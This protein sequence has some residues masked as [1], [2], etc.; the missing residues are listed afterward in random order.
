M[1]RPQYGVSVT[2][3][4][5]FRRDFFRA[6]DTGP[7]DPATDARYLPLYEPE[8]D[9]ILRLKE[10]INFAHG[11][12]AQLLSGYR[13]AGKSTELRRLRQ[14]LQAEG[15]DYAVL[16]I[17]VE[18]YLDLHMPIDITEFLLA[19]CGAVGEKLQEGEFLKGSPLKASLGQRF[20]NFLNSEVQL[21]EF[22][23]TAKAGVKAEGAEVGLDASAKVELKTNPL[24]RQKIQAALANSL[25]QFTTEVRGF[26]AECALAVD[27]H[28]KGAG[29]V[30]LVDSIEHARGTNETEAKVHE[31]LERL[32]ADH[33]DK[34][35]LPGV[36]L[37]Y[38]VPPWL[39]IRRPNIGAPYSGAG[40]HTLPAQ[41][42]RTYAPGD[43]EGK[44]FAPGLKRLTELVAKRGD[45]Q[46]LLGNKAALEELIL[47]TGGHLRDLIRLLQ[48]VAVETTTLPATTK[49][50][51]AA[52]ERLRAQFTPIPLDDVR[53]LAEIARSHE[54]DLQNLDKVGTL[55]RYFDSHLVLCYQNG[56]EW[57]DVHPIVR[58]LVL[59]QAARLK[60]ADGDG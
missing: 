26:F 41:K 43:L 8:S 42:V 51:A 47:A 14:L 1:R 56:A 4:R 12:S 23:L 45:W 19:L 59:E 32:F 53:W 5:N 10:T 22:S 2:D 48:T 57:Y 27:K 24:F 39:R 58:S 36:H 28:H 54:A 7:L 49:T 35:K 40:L 6:L 11:R 37:V 30:I 13:G 20:W 17:D 38:T 34:L 29:L 52:Q 33:D 55:A 44:P 50:L 31:A 21:K 18:D 9:V 46:R 15:E 3:D 25:G 16:L 60:P